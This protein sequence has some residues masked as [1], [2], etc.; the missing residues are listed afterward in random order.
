M[1]DHLPQRGR[2]VNVSV[3]STIQ[4]VQGVSL[5]KK[6]PSACQLLP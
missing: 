2:P 3:I 4:M 5:Q 1:L 6:M